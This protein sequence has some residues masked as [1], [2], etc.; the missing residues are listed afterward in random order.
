MPTLIFFFLKIN[1]GFN[2]VR[3]RHISRFERQ[4]MYVAVQNM[5]AKM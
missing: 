1:E 5:T 2:F 4:G 3:A